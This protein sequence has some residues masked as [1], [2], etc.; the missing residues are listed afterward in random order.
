MAELRKCGRCRSEIE[1]TYVGINRK[2]EHN[3]TCVICL[4]KQGHTN[5]HQNSKHLNIIIRQLGLYVII[6]DVM[7]IQVAYQHIKIICYCQVCNMEEN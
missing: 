4:D 1:L 5:K 7:L 3:I 6:V 2:G